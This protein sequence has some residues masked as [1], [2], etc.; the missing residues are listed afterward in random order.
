MPVEDI[1]SESDSEEKHAIMAEENLLQLEEAEKVVMKTLFI[2]IDI[3]FSFSIH[4]PTQNNLVIDSLTGSPLPDDLML[5]SVPVCAPYS[6]LHDYK[7][8]T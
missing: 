6:A 5:F 8:E 4:P 2:D 7:Y 1:E 3:Q